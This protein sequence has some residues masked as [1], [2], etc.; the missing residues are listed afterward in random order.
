MLNENVEVLN[1]PKNRVSI[2]S[3]SKARLI[4]VYLFSDFLDFHFH[5]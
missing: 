4:L 1:L 5:Y 3:S 2:G